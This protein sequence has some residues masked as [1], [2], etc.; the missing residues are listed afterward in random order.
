MIG[1]NYMIDLHHQY[2]Y[3]IINIDFI[4]IQNIIINIEESI[5]N[6]LAQYE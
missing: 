4:V 3:Q 2:I 5:I 1:H 6:S